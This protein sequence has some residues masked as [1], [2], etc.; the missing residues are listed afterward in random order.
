MAAIDAGATRRSA[1]TARA[2]SRKPHQP[3]FQT[4]DYNPL[5]GGIERWF[6]P[7]HDAISNGATLTNLLALAHREFQ[8][9]SPNVHA[10][11]VEVHQFRIEARADVPGQPTPEGIHRDGVDWVLVALVSRRNIRSGMTTVHAPDGKQLGS[12]TLTEPLDAAWVDD[13]RVF[14]GVTAV[15]PLDASQPAFRDVLVVTFRSEPSRS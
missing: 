10:W 15:E 14:H 12:F 2:S 4:R 13:N 5:N 6:E 9:R 11:H 7:I 8:A 3:H 1:R